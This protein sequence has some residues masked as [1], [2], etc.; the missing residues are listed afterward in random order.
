MPPCVA[1]V[2]ALDS[3]AVETIT[4]IASDLGL[5]DA[6]LDPYGRSIAKINTV[7]PAA[8]GKGRL[9]LVS[10][11]NPASSGEGKTTVSVGLAM[12]MRRLKKK[13]VL[14]LREPSLGPIF[15]LKGGATGGGK[16]VLVP[17]DDINLHFTGDMH[18]ITA[19]HNLLSAL[20]DNAL[21]FDTPC[22]EAGLLNPRQVAWPR[23]LDMNDRSLRHCIVGLGNKTDGVPRQTRFDITAASEIMAIMALS[24]DMEDLQ[25][26]LARIVVGTS[27][28]GRPVTAGDLDA[29]G[30]MAV[31][32]RHALKPNLVQTAEGG[33][34]LVHCGPFANIAHG[35]SSLLATRQGMHMGDYVV[36]EAGFGFDLG[37]EKFL[38][39]KCRTG[40]IWPR[41]V[42]V[43]AS[44]RSLKMHAGASLAHAVEPDAAS[45]KAGMAH[46]NKHLESV[47]SFGLTPVVA[48]NRFAQDTD[49]EVAWA[50]KSVRDGGTHAA[51]VDAFSRGGEGALELA[52]AVISV[53]D[54]NAPAPRF[55]YS[56]E[57]SAQD[58]VRKVAR[59]LY[60]ADDVAF[61]PAAVTQLKRFEEQG[62]GSLPV[63][64]AKTPLS[65]SD[66]PARVGRPSG[67]TV[68][69]REVRLS[70]GAGF[71]VMLTG[72]VNTMPGLPR[73]PASR[74]I[75]LG[76]DGAVVWN[77]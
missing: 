28:Q 77:A 56:L 64:M 4:Q 12:G 42:V 44:L 46:L 3:A 5:Q 48:F 7:P 68:T 23:V 49:E 11:I 74:R 39:L 73:V 58:K 50:L 76:Q 26:R 60:G 37:G 71:L 62:Y 51:C 15:G 70:A 53:A 41:A 34:A 29:Q 27:L 65:L 33:P 38:N 20:V 31:L 14:C 69:V 61:T 10:A 18:A 55:T 17:S 6:S 36:T 66:D 16:A 25:R 30:A 19:A 63:C 40:G 43:V 45:L 59:T 52:E 57:D 8:A 54:G 9:I 72:E 24:S 75:R 21:H 22:G 35:C 32:L 1:P 2:Q 13:V 47:A 67:F